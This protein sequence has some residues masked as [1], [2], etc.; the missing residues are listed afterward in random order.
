MTRYRPDTVIVDEDEAGRGRLIRRLH[1]E[2]QREPTSKRAMNRKGVQ[3]L[4]TTFPWVFWGFHGK[5]KI[6]I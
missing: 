2:E 5:Y 6:F 4:R 1:G 3:G